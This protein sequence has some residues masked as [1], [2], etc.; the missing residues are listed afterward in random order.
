VLLAPTV[1]FVTALAAYIPAR[2]ASHTNPM[3]ALRCE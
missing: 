1:L 3:Q 2:R